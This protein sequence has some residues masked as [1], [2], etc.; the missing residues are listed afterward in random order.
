M[1]RSRV[2][3]ALLLA[4]QLSTAGGIGSGPT[5]FGDAQSRRHDPRDRAMDM[6]HLLLRVSLDHEKRRIE[7]EATLTMKPL[8]DGVS[9]V[10]LD[11]AELSVRS[12]Y[13]EGAGEVPFRHDGETLRVEL[14]RPAKT[15]E[16]LKLTVAYDGQPRKGIYFVGPDEGYPS[17][18]RQA[19][20]QG[21]AEDNRYWF[22]SYD[23]PNDKITSEVIVT[24]ASTETAVSNGTLVEV[25]DE[26]K[27]KTRT[28][29]W[30]MDQPHSSYLVSIAVGEFERVDDAWDGIPVQY[31]V[32]KGTGREKTLRSFGST[33][34]MLRFF[35]ERIGVRYPYS[36]YAQCCVVDFIFGG[37]ENVTATTQTAATLHGPEAEPE[38]SSQGL[39]AHE[40]AHQWWGDLLTCRDW[41]H[42]WL[43]EGFTTYFEALYREHRN[44]VDE[45]R[46]AML[47]AARTYLE[48][49]ATQYRRAIVTNLYTEPMDLFDAHLYPKGAWCLHMIRGILGDDLFFKA[50]HRYAEANAWKN[51]ITD[52]LRRAIEEATGRNLDWFFD[53]WLYRGGHP[54]FHV[55]TSWDEDAGMLRVA[56]SQ[57]QTPDDLTP[58]FRMPVD[59]DV[60]TSRGVQTYRV[61]VSK[62]SHEFTFPC[63]EEPLLTRFD[64][65]HRILKT[66][67]QPRSLRELEY[68]STHDDD[69][70]GRAL[71]AEDLGKR[72][73]DPAAAKILD[74]MAQTD[75][76]WGVRAEAAAALGRVGGSGAWPGLRIALADK[77]S[78][79]RAAAAAALNTATGDAE[80]VAALEARFASDSSPFVRAASL[81]A[82]AKLKAPRASD[83]AVRAL[84]MDSPGEVIRTQAL[85][86]LLV[87]EDSRT[88]ELAVEWTPYG[89][90]VEAR[91]AAAAV[92]SRASDSTGKARECLVKL[93]DD[94]AFHVRRAALSALR[95]LG[96]PKT[97][98]ALATRETSEVD[99]RLRKAAR[100]AV[101]AI[102]SAGDRALPIS[103]LRADVERLRRENAQLNERIEALERKKP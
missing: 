78:R 20:T 41:A 37:M 82:L 29:H 57:T 93:L 5:R 95:E 79:V 16:T 24:V 19:W 54:D 11:A 91:T 81:G 65:H 98:D 7:G 2:L 89:K 60:E 96:D 56:V 97:L 26:P 22:P 47:G 80:T 100:D 61:E 62:P 55:E 52:D 64:P 99:A 92:L 86:A 15:T 72:A 51:V 59:I 94:R 34:D 36:K 21:E 40:L 44:G 10:D 8:V 73:G 33:P 39:V 69:V 1:I 31:F 4:S 48:E 3:A 53:E 42:A 101:Q 43:N 45:F 74:V 18:P 35:S 75:R 27:D 17:K 14:P 88:V 76:F 67:D 9:R 84:S 46:Y 68:A 12:V 58:V 87:L 38:R 103:T 90:P 66:L 30:R 71:V 28:F 32:P 13:L 63:A 23:Y 83:L 6:Q 70:V 25:L 50:I 102:R 77:D 85:E 49:D